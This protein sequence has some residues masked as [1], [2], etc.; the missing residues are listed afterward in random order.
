MYRPYVKLL[1]QYTTYC[2]GLF[3]WQLQWVLDYK[4]VSVVGLY[5]IAPP[6]EQV[7]AMGS[8]LQNHQCGRV[9]HH[10]STYLPGWC[11]GS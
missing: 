5:I 1:H 4:I 7:G 9:V 11:N 3:P 8:R 2:M 10:C 6:M